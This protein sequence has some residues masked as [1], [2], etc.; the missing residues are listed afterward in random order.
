MLEPFSGALTEIWCS[1]WIVS[2]TVTSRVVRKRDN[3]DKF[4]Y[5]TACAAGAIILHGVVDHL[6]G[7]SASAQTCVC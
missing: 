4:L 5:T 7:S 6:T 3:H 1:G 2:T